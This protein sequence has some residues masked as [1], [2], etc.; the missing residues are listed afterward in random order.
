MIF[1]GIG[2]VFSTV[3]EKQYETIGAF[4]DELAA[5]YGRDKLRGLGYGW[6]DTE[7]K[8]VI[9]LKEGTIDGCDTRVEL[10]D[11]GWTTVTGRTERLGEMYG[12]IYMDGALLF[13]IEMF[14]DDGNCRLMYIRAPLKTS[15]RPFAPP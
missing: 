3:G 11:E 15:C 14:D 10:P 12:E 7:I 6:T 9:G 8:Y 5:K 2:R 1:E 4:W 13:E